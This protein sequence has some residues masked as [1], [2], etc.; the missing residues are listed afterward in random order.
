M[1]WEVLEC[2]QADGGLDWKGGVRGCGT[3][4]V[5][6]ARYSRQGRKERGVL[7]CLAMPL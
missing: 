5:A 7:G 3:A 4:P 1:N 6:S 2:A